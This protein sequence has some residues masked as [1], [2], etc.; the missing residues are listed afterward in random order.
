MALGN[1]MGNLIFYCA[2]IK[3]KNSGLYWSEICM[4]VLL[5]FDMREADELLQCS[6]KVMQIECYVGN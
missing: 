5:L 2:L 3:Q 1:V 6:K 4:L